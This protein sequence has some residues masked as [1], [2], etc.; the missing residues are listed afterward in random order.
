MWGSAYD[1]F[2]PLKYIYLDV[3]RKC[4]LEKFFNFT[5][6]QYHSILHF[7]KTDSISN[8]I[9]CIV[10]P[11]CMLISFCAVWLFNSMPIYGTQK[12]II[13]HTYKYNLL[14][15]INLPQFLFIGGFTS[16]KKGKFSCLEIYENVFVSK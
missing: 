12:S 7:L 6:I 2:L 13:L 9:V 4:H 5:S 3:N 1:N 10:P 16:I 11:S 8:Y 15:W 14:T